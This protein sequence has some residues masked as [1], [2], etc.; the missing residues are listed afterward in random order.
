MKTILFVLLLAFPMMAFS[1]TIFGTVTSADG[2]PMKGVKVVAEG[3]TNGTL[4]DEKGA[5]SLK[6]A[7][8]AAVTAMIF[9]SKE[10]KKPMT[11]KMKTGLLTD[12]RL[13]VTMDKKKKKQKF[14]LAN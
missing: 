2:M 11:I 13:F 9:T 10:L 6:V 8:G 14:L 7:N 4:T 5:Y 1:Q 3:T 12:T